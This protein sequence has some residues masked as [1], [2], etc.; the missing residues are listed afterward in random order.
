VK[1]AITPSGPVRATVP[2][3][4]SK[5]LT[6]RALV[7]AALAPG[8][9][10]IHDPSDSDDTGLLANGLNQLGVLVRRAPGIMIVD[11]TGGKLYAPRFPI[12]V[13]NAG[14]TLR[15]LLSVAA[16]ARGTTIIEGNERMAGRP[17][18]DLVESLH[19]LGV[20]V[21]HDVGTSRFEVDGGSLAG[22][23]V[24]VKGQKSSQFLSSLLLVAPYARAEMTIRVAEGLTS[25]SYVG[26]TLDVMSHFGA[27][28]LQPDA[29]TFVVHPGNRYLLADY[30]VEADASSGSYPLA[31]A[32]ITGGDVYV[33]GMR[34]HSRQGDGGFAA[35][36]G[37]M[38]CRVEYDG[39]GVR[40]T[41]TGTLRGIEVDMNAMPDVVPTLLVVA[42]F[43]DGVTRITNV[44]QLRY[45]ESDRA[46]GFAGELAKLGADVR[47]AGDAIEVHPGPLHGALLDTEDDHRRAMSFA[48]A[49]LRVPGVE[50]ENP[51]CVRKSFPDFW[52][53]FDGMT[54]G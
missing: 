9:S 8:T 28:V 51:D 53:A 2:V 38:G 52:K 49:G 54:K 48:L 35:I 12:P 31:A 32:A 15:F 17:N 40:V 24:N 19:S 41:G 1:R 18:E 14:T 42:L 47:V 20:G 46:E 11:G 37:R 45:K 16:L 30:T 26:L 43:A 36:L 29:F 3:P 27:P 13:G 34:E 50:I 33:P 5:S 10:Q 22:G 44:G 21:R 6:N 39:K 4:G 7:C 25:A 23:R